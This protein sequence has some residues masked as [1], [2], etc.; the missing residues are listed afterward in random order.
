MQFL[1]QD[2]LYVYFRYDDHQTVMCIVNAGDAEKNISQG[3]YAERTKG[4]SK[5]VDVINGATYPLPGDHRIAAKTT[6]VWVLK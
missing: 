5:A 2:G 6:Q 3:R 1:P 4:F